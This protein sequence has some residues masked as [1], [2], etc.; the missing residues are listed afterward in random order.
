MGTYDWTGTNGN[1]WDSAV[2]QT[3]N[4]AGGTVDIQSNKGRVLTSATPY[5]APQATHAEASRNLD[6]TVRV[7][8]ANPIVE[9]YF[10]VAYRFDW[11]SAN[12]GWPENGYHF[13]IA[14]QSHTVKFTRDN[15]AAR[16]DIDA[17]GTYTPTAGV[18]T[19]VRVNVNDNQHRLKVWTDGSSEPSAWL[20]DI[21][22]TAF[23]N[24]GKWGIAFSSGAATTTMNADDLTYET[25]PLVPYIAQEVGNQVTNAAALTTV[26]NFAGAVKPQV[27]DLVVVYGSRDNTTNDAPSGS[28]DTFTD[29]QSNTWNLA[30]PLAQPAGTST[31]LAGI[32]GVFFWSKITTAWAGGTNVLTW[33]HPSTKA[34]MSLEH[35]RNVGSFRSSNSAGSAAGAPSVALA[36]PV[37]YDLVL[38]MEAI[39]YSTAGTS[40]EDADTTNGVWYPINGPYA[41]TGTT[42]AAV[43]VISQWKIVSATGTQ[44]FNPTHSVTTNVDCVAIIA[45]F[46][47]PPIPPGASRYY[48]KAAAQRAAVR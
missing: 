38:G 45:A 13:E 46:T 14:A 9:Q 42:L 4:S 23:P 12:N 39:E 32:V 6:M 29:S 34:S 36:T 22:N 24:G 30:S 18:D 17:T 5:A 25:G 15:F 10:I 16:T 43:K 35:W 48:Y 27:G 33:N 37:Q 19:W 44:T 28:T 47:P 20:Y 3:I 21:T 8:W 2:W 31:A 26:L 11:W 1:A 41:T 7:T 40:T